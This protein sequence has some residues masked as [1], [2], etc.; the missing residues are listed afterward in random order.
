[1]LRMTEKQYQQPELQGLKF[2][3]N[4]GL[5]PHGVRRSEAV[6]LFT[7]FLAYCLQKFRSILLSIYS[8]CHVHFRSTASRCAVYRKYGSN[9][10][11]VLLQEGSSSCVFPVHITLLLLGPRYW[12]PSVYLIQYSVSSVL[13]QQGNVFYLSEGKGM[14]QVSER[15]AGQGCK[16]PS[17]RHGHSAAVTTSCPLCCLLFVSHSHLNWSRRLS[18]YP[19]S[20]EY[21]LHSQPL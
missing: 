14:E 13:K 6:F 19:V 8:Y 9:F 15:E 21:L 16:V 5:L 11:I 2:L 1:M 17:A 18:K 4:S 10:C 3:A 12:M 7:D 20:S